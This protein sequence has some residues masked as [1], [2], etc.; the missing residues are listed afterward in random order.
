MFTGGKSERVVRLLPQT[1][2][3]AHFAGE[4]IILQKLAWWV[5]IHFPSSEETPVQLKEH[6][7]LAVV[8]EV[9]HAP[10]GHGRAIFQA[11]SCAPG[12]LVKETRRGCGVKKFDLLREQEGLPFLRLLVKPQVQELRPLSLLRNRN[13]VKK[14]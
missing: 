10:V 14:D 9:P 7:P 13:G 5:G 11:V 1:F 6:R 8:I 12:H 2:Q 4:I 3:A